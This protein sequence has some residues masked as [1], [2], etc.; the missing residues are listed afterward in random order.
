MTG[1]WQEQL[2]RIERWHKRILAAQNAEDGVDFLYA[3]FEGSFAL[4]D[5]LIDT[6]TVT[7]QQLEGLF[8]QHV[9]LRINRDIANS[10]KHHSITR[11][12]QEQPPSIIREYAPENPS[13]GSASRLVILSEGQQ[14]DAIDLAGRCLAIWQEYTTLLK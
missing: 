3:F 12:S 8:S 10:F 11:P 4:R 7:Q 13:F 6:G 5:W 9:E 2:S 1:G 14:Y